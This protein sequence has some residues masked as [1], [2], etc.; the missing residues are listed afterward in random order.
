MGV[1]MSLKKLAAGSGYEYLTEQVAAY[2]STELGK[3]PLA[4]YYAL[5]GEAPGGW[6]G[7]GPRSLT[8]GFRV[9]KKPPRSPGFR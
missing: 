5:K 4:D 8:A 6:V 1:T 3:V 7:S 2:D 9:S